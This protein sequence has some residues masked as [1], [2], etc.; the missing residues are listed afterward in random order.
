[1]DRV[2]LNAKDGMILTDGKTYGETIYLENGR[3]ADEF[4]EITKEE[5]NRITEREGSE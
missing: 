4:Y 3:T 1:M 5:Y 2:I